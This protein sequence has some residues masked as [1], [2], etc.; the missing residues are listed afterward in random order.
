MHK[1]TLG[2][3]LMAGIAC[4]GLAAAASALS[5]APDWTA[6]SNQADAHLGSSV[7]GAGDVNG[8]GYDD[9]IVGVPDWDNAYGADCGLAYVYYGSVS[10][11]ASTPAWSYEG[12]QAGE[13]L[14]FSVASAGDVNHDGYAD[15]IIGDPYWDYYSIDGG[16]VLVFYGSSSGL[17]ATPTWYYEAPDGNWNN[18]YLGYSVAC[19]GDVNGDGYDDV[20]TGAPG[21]SGNGY[22]CVFHGSSTGLN[23]SPAY[24]EGGWGGSFYGCAVSSAGDFNRD[25]Y[26]DIIVGAKDYSQTATHEG[27]V[28]LRLGSSGGM[29]G[30]M[31]QFASQQTEAFLGCS[32]ACANDIN[33]DNYPDIIAGAYNYSNGQGAEGRVYVF[34][35]SASNGLPSSGT[36]DWA[37]ESNQA[38]A[39]FGYSVAGVGDVNHDSLPDVLIGAYGYT[40]HNN[41][42]GRAYIFYGSVTGLASSP[43]WTTDGGQVGAYCGYSVAGAGDVNKDGFLDVLVSASRFSNGQSHEGLTYLYL[44]ASDVT[45][46]PTPTPTIRPVVTFTPTRIFPAQGSSLQI[47]LLPSRFNPATGG[48]CMIHWQQPEAGAVTI[49]IYTLTGRLVK[50]FDRLAFPV[51]E[52][53]IRWDG[54]DDSGQ[55][56]ATG[57]YFVHIHAGSYENTAKAAIIK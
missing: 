53:E 6:E 8:D 33:Q 29:S 48:F 25:G 17:P 46:T 14:G 39:Y 22:I 57:I 44:S 50:T 24:A 18:A 13:H 56:A 27:I 7:A 20:I 21:W 28:Q 38:G 31:Y 23:A 42:E 36:P 1:R 9:V 5:A 3:G 26:D 10:G 35:G 15:V 19:A 34:Y 45:P 30:T 40:N 12:T 4:M 52:H 41:T 55:G 16:Q 2:M 49:R 11:L 43:A 47:K 32:V 54:R 37:M 51:G